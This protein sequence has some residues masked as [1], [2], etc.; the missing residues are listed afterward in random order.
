[1][2]WNPRTQHRLLALGLGMLA[3]AA[4]LT[5]LT[6][7]LAVVAATQ[8]WH[9]GTWLP[10]TQTPRPV[11]LLLGLDVLFAGVGLLL[12]SV[13]LVAGDLTVRARR[14]AF[15]AIGVV[16]ALLLAGTMGAYRALDPV[17]GRVVPGLVAA[18][19]LVALGWPHVRS[20]L[21][22][23]ISGEL[24]AL[25]AVA[26]LVADHAFLEA[27]AAPDSASSAL[28]WNIAPPLVGMLAMVLLAVAYGVTR[29]PKAPEGDVSMPVPSAPDG[30]AP[31]G[32]FVRG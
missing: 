13:V 19:G 17:A 1:M 3:G 7:A 6:E 26:R 9:A 22:L 14:T 32:D 20:R 8:A 23:A 24:V 10:R 25:R 18:A 11:A 30:I 5:A 28:A 4:A 12:M 31:L 2:G 29:S 21:L 27:A 15:L 16:G